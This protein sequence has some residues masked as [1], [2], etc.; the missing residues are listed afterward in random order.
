MARNSVGAWARAKNALWMPIATGAGRA[1]TSIADAFR[2]SI[3]PTRFTTSAFLEDFLFDIR[4]RGAP[5]CAMTCSF[6]F[7]GVSTTNFGG[8]HAISMDHSC[9]LGNCCGGWMWRWRIR[10]W[11][12][13]WSRW[14]DLIRIRRYGHGRRRQWRQWRLGPHAARVSRIGCLSS[15]TT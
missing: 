10:I 14:L 13:C 12:R 2:Q 1:S 4:R 3:V 9:L 15:R 6:R 11:G 5:N 8:H 7:A